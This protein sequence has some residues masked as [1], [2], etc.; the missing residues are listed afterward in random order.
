MLK[1][2]IKDLQAKEICVPF[3]S[4]SSEKD[5]VKDKN[6]AGYT[7]SFLHSESKCICVVNVSIV[8]KIAVLPSAKK[9][10]IDSHEL[11]FWKNLIDAFCVW[12]QDTSLKCVLQNIFAENAIENT[13]FLFVTK[14]KKEIA[15]LAK[16]KSK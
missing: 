11:I 5:E 4:T 6:R 8:Q 15:M 7:A 16:W 10:L 13:T 12:N 9:W 3:K 1:Y 2:F 14:E